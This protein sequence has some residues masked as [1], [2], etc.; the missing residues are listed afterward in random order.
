MA[1]LF[2]FFSPYTVPVV[3]AIRVKLKEKAIYIVSHIWVLPESHGT[4]KK[5]KQ[6]KELL[7][8]SARNRSSSA[9]LCVC[10]CSETLQKPFVSFVSFVIIIIS[11]ACESR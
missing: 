10:V 9:P 4:E 11:G 5:K 2:F 1:V 7:G 6:N 3:F 8:G